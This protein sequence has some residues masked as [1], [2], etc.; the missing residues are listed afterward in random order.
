FHRRRHVEGAIVIER[1][2][3]MRALNTA[4]IDADLALQLQILRLTAEMAH[5]YIFGRNGRIRF[6]LET[7]MS[8]IP[9]VRQQSAGCG[10]NALVQFVEWNAGQISQR[11]LIVHVVHLK[12]RSRW[13]RP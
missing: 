8:V 4:Q 12:P 2:S 9:A 7:E 13:T 3:A 1:P 5:E 6:E 11:R 10:G